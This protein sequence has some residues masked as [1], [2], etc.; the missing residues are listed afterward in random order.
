MALIK[1]S[2]VKESDGQVFKT[3]NAGNYP[4]R[5][6]N[7]EEKKSGPNSKHPGSPYLNLTF[8][9]TDDE[10]KG[11]TLWYMINLPNENMDSEDVRKCVASMKR[12]MVAMQIPIPEDEEI[13]TQ[14]F[15]GAEALGVVQIETKDGQA[16]NVLKD[17]LQK[18]D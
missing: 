11:T 8:K 17:L 16:K 7:V 10:T 9:T 14:D 15:I 4:V 18:K 2:G 1:V 5:C 12:A 6:A 13:D 3:I